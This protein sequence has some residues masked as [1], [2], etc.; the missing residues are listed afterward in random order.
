MVVK[1]IFQFHGLLA[2]WSNYLT[3]QNLNN[4]ICKMCLVIL[5]RGVVV[6]VFQFSGL[7]FI[8]THSF[9][10]SISEIL[11]TVLQLAF[12]RR[13]QASIYRA[14]SFFLAALQM[15][16]VLFKG[17]CQTPCSPPPDIWQVLPEQKSLAEPLTGQSALQ[18][19]GARRYFHFYCAN[20]RVFLV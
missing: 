20:L 6:R 13:F 5:P 9:I 4:F 15:N 2:V 3:S 10:F 7:A 16:H 14:T 18:A 12:F 8:W 11:S 17:W 1:I 19:G